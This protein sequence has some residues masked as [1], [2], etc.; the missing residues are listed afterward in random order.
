MSSSLPS[1]KTIGY[2]RTA[3]LSLGLAGSLLGLTEGERH[4]CTAASTH[5]VIC[6]IH[7]EA[8]FGLIASAKPIEQREVISIKQTSRGRLCESRIEKPGFRGSPY[9]FESQFNWWGSQ[10]PR[11]QA[12]KQ[13]AELLQLGDGA[14]ASFSPQIG[15]LRFEKIIAGIVALLCALLL[16]RDWEHHRFNPQRSNQTP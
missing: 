6:N 1:G 9:Y 14:S 3:L 2:V 11:C 7:S 8:L 13:L 10:S 16:I 12:S 15:L 5:R 4:Y